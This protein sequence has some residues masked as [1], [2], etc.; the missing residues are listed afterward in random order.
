M[1]S[2]LLF[3]LLPILFFFISVGISCRILKWSL[4]EGGSFVVTNTVLA[5]LITL[6]SSSFR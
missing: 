6:L 2:S 5:L 4:S 1:T 3:D